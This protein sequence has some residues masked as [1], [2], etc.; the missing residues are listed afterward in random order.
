MDYKLVTY[1]HLVIG[2]EIK[3]TTIGE[4]SRY[5]S[6]FVTSIN[7]AYVIVEMWRKNGKEA[8]IDSSLMFMV[9][10]SKKRI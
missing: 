3:G 9:E 7:P 1:K 10:M 8:K 4:C 5:F 2:Q 6:A